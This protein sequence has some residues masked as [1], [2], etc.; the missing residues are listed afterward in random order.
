MSSTKR[1][2]FSIEEKSVIIQRLEAGES[3]GTLAK[4]FGVSHSTISTIKKNK[5]KI[6]HLFNANVLK[7]KR[8]RASTQEQVGEALLQ[9]F[10]L[11][12][13][14]GIPVNGPMLQRKADFFAKQ[15]NIGNF[16]CSASWI[17]RFKVRHNIVAGKIAGE[18][19]SVQQSDVNE[20]LTKV[21]PSL[22]AQFSNDEIFNADE[23]G[24]FYKLTPDKTLKFKGEK[25]TGGKLS[26][27]RITVMVAA[28]MSG[29]VKKKNC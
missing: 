15:L 7:P 4:E 24:L 21:W 6:E 22:R 25:C 5:V 23:M 10:K 18:S 20:W 29:T 9:W 8:V 19:L 3:N 11:Q 2:C 1:K 16:N 17:N 26:K 27:E 28:N 14:R 13:D 12:R